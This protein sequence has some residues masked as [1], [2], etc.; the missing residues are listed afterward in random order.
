MQIGGGAQWRHTIETELNSAKCV[1]VAWSKRSVGTEG[2]FVQDEATRAQE[3]HVY[4]PVLIDK[5]HLP[6]GFGEMQALPLGG[7]KGD[8]ADG[9][10]QAVLAS[11]KRIA[12]DFEGQAKPHAGGSV[13]R[14]GALVGGTAA[15]GLAI[16]GVGGW[17]L[18]RPSAASATGSIAVLPFANLSG[19]PS[20]AFF[21]DGI[22]EEIRS[23]LGRLAGLKVVGRTSSEAVRS[24]DAQT[25]ARKL[26]VAN[27]LT[28]SVRQSAST[29]RIT[30]ELI[31]GKTGLD[32][33]SQDYD[34]RP[35]DS[36][37]IQT[38]I[39]QNVATALSSTLGDAAKAAATVGGTDN[40]EAQRLF[41]QAGAILDRDFTSA[42]VHQAFRLLD[43]AIALDPNY[44]SAYARKSGVLIGYGNS[45]SKSA[46]ELAD[47]RAESL[48]LVRTALRIAPDLP[49]AHLALAAVYSSTLHMGPAFAEAKRA[50][51]L[52]PGDAFIISR[53][54]S[55]ASR[56][57][58]AD[59][60]LQTANQAI[61][62]DPLNNNSYNLRLDALFYVR[63][64]ADVVTRGQELEHSPTLKL[65]GSDVVGNA[66][67]LLGKYR[68]AESY[69]S[70]LAPD[71]WSRMTGEA[72][73]LARTGDRAG[74]LRKMQALQREYRDAAS[75]QYAQIYAQL[76]DKDA[77][78]ANLEHGFAIKDAGLSAMKVDPF[79]DPLRSDARFDAL[80]RRMDLSA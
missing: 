30:A 75:Y 41:I 39:A 33:W 35:G 67:V 55:F 62:L 29:I 64:F 16:A 46:Q 73:I 4:I 14:R 70:Q 72:V 53:Y 31:D 28:G 49:Q 68:E 11:V 34:R 1:I 51:Q 19:D 44:A 50:S 10:Y 52:A 3:R 21:S 32:R 56:Q 5:V 43:S 66:L 42:T 24:D 59:E 48:R 36:I 79:V 78:F 22:A 54:A 61:S 7:W 47:T 74:A 80:L 40:A 27:I 25:A 12:G 37:K 15:A 8:R 20:Q 65:T 76:G 63:R 6:L 58:F 71:F 17:A 9:R 23:A 60:G 38:D 77:A 18:L 26:D 2:T 13:T 69:Y 57:G 45:Y